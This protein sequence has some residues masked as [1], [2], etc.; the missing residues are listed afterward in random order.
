MTRPDFNTIPDFHKR[1]VEHVKDFD[2]LEALRISS[3]RTV[4][5]VRSIPEDQGNYRY[6]PLKWSIKELLCH[7]MDTERILAYRALRFGRND[8]TALHGFEEN[9]Y[10]PEANAE[11]RKV[12]QIADEMERLRLTTL[13]L[14]VNF[15]PEM[16]MRKGLANNLELSVI[17][18]GYI[19]SG[20]ESH[21]LQI[22]KERY[23]PGLQ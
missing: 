6:A 22:L 13:D 9:D 3:K 11:N 15:T 14:F 19:I 21:H 23:L 16:L 7:M 5:V 2:V 20:H 1:Y 17:N 12:K 4:D 18:L 10:A 8:K